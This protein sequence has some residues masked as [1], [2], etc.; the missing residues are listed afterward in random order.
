MWREGTLRFGG[1]DAAK[2]SFRCPRM[3]GEAIIDFV[4]LRANLELDHTESRR[5]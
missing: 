5:S 3:A 1:K 4:A 2:P